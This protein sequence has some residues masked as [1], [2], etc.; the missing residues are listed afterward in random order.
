MHIHLAALSTAGGH[1]MLCVITL[2]P[3]CVQVQASL[4]SHI[5]S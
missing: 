3:L 1:A 2:L 5:Q 4:D